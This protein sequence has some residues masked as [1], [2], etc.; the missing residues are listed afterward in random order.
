MKAQTARRPQVLT[1]NTKDDILDLIIQCKPI[2]RIA[3][4][5]GVPETHIYRALATDAAFRKAYEAAKVIQLYR[6]EE[7]LL[8]EAGG[9]WSDADPKEIERLLAVTKELIA[10]RT[11]K[12]RSL[13]GPL[14]DLAFRFLSFEPEDE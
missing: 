7:I 8:D 4:D 13:D 1:D 2:P 11:P 3:S 14:Q 9:P 5:L 12:I 10:R 6:L